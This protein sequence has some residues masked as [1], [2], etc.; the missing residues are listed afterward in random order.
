M[1][2]ATPAFS[3]V[4][5]LGAEG[6]GTAL[7]L[8]I[9][10]G[11]GVMGERLSDGSAAIALMLNAGSTGA[12]LAV[13]ITLLG[14]ISGAHFNPLVTL[15]AWRDGELD[16]R[17]ALA[18]GAVQVIAGGVGV[19][20]AHA[21][22]ALPLIQVSDT[23]RSGEGQVL[24]EGIA[25]FGLILVIRLAKRL[26]SGAT[27]SLVALYISAA[28]GF[29]AST[30]FA[31]PAVTLARSLTDTFAGIAPGSIPGFLLGQAI[32]ALAATVIAGWLLVER[33]APLPPTA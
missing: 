5:R 9:V 16:I 32:G 10:V 3:L 33:P 15:L 8:A 7:L 24:S 6:L 1:T 29:T 28:Y 2:T 4:R 30:A 20:A 19:L 27:A 18:R 11:S 17:E 13:L 31:N 12:G 21:M 14:P 25:T 26:A 23:L 22:F